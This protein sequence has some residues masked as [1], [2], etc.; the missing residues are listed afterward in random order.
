M[1]PEQLA[2]GV[3]V[4]VVRRWPHMVPFV[5]GS[6]RVVSSGQDI[7]YVAQRSNA[8]GA[9]AGEFFDPCELY[10]SREAAEESLEKASSG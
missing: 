3:K 9:V 5:Q 8:G 10:E 6:F 2:I 1:N 7:A 4:W